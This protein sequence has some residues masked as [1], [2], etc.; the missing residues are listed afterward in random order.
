MRRLLLAARA[1]ADF[2][3]PDDY[4]GV[5]AREILASLQQELTVTLSRKHPDWDVAAIAGEVQRKM[6]HHYGPL[7]AFV[8]E[9]SQQPEGQEWTQDLPHN[10]KK[11]YNLHAGEDRGVTWWDRDRDIVW[12][13]SADFHR[14]GSRDDFYPAMVALDADHSLM[15]DAQDFLDADPDPTEEYL[16]EL[17]EAGRQL[18]QQGRDQPAYE[19]STLVAGRM[20]LGI[21]IEV[22]VIE[23]DSAEEVWIRVRATPDHHGTDVVQDIL[24]V[25]IPEAQPEHIDFPQDHPGRRLESGERIIRWMCP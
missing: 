13:L 20:T 22:I 5:D 11:V 1:R 25:V 16:R 14:S 8:R 18:L 2:G 21:Y 23:Q 19:H 17:E 15:P 6:A 3:L 24:D 7:I 9:R 12:L 10:Y 4:A